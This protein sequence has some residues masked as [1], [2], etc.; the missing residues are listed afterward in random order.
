MQ[1]QENIYFSFDRLQYHKNV[2]EKRIP[3]IR[4]LSMENFYSHIIKFFVSS[5]F[6]F[7]LISFCTLSDHKRTTSFLLPEFISLSLYLSCSIES[8]RC[9]WS[10]WY[11]NFQG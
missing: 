6:L 3:F 5:T 10:S 11:S 7:L 4:A 2:I 8:A 1:I 9:S